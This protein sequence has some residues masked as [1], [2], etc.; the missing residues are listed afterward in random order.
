MDRDRYEV[1]CLPRLH[2]GA[3]IAIDTR[4]FSTIMLDRSKVPAEPIFETYGRCERFD[5]PDE[6]QYLYQDFSQN[7]KDC[8]KGLV[9]FHE[10]RITEWFNT[11]GWHTQKFHRLQF[12]GGI[13][14]RLLQRILTERENPFVNFDD[15]RIRLKVDIRQMLSISLTN[16]VMEQK[17]RLVPLL[18]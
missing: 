6:H 12:I 11:A 15:M 2:A 18:R 8:F 3:V 7:L 17:F 1:W 4:D 14:G 10:K 13:R 9:C 16:E 5:L